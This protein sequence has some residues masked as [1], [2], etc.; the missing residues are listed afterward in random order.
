VAEQPGC[1]WVLAGT[2]GAGKSSI[3]GE[4]LRRSG[5]DYYNP[6]EV[7]RRL[8][9]AHPE[10]TPAQ[11]NGRAWHEGVRLLAEAIGKRHSHFFETTLGGDSIVALLESACDAGLAVRIWYAG[12]ASPELQIARVAARVAKGGHAIPEDHIRRR[13]D[14]SRRNLIRLLPRLTELQVHDNSIE[15]DPARGAA[16]RLRLLLRWVAGRIVAPRN[17]RGT[18]DWAR[19]VVAAALKSERA[20]R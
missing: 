3:G 19:P 9:V 18:P 2:D 11:A 13:Y 15:A 14:N 4:F 20:R 10:L 1:I 17:L 12:L 7:A 8:L 6:D 16:P 5:G